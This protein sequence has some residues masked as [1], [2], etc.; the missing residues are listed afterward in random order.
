MQYT[1][2]ISVLLGFF[3]FTSLFWGGFIFLVIAT[4]IH[5]LCDYAQYVT[6]NREIIVTLKSY[7]P[8]KN[9]S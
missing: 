6:M 5:G 7:I 1:L 3:K 8:V 9:M 4:S 2:G